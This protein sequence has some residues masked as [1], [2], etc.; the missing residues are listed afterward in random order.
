MTDTHA[1]EVIVIGGGAAGLSAALV[2]GRARRRTLVVD[3]GEPRNAPSAHM[4]GY[5]SRDGMSPAEF[6]AIGREEISRYGVELVRDRVVDV[7]QGFGVTLA[8]G[9]TLRARRLVIATGL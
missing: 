5:L 9:R 7:S 1:Y 6:L 8:S 4:Q 2:L 3:A